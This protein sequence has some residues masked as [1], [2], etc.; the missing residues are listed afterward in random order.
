MISAGNEEDR[1]EN[2]RIGARII[3]GGIMAIGIIG[4]TEQ[5]FWFLCFGPAPAGPFVSAANW[6]G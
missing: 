4:A 1:N 3:A 2:T 5:R 6:R